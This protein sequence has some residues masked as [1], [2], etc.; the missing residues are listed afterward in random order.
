MGLRHFSELNVSRRR[1]C[2]NSESEL[3]RGQINKL[4]RII[5]KGFK[6]ATCQLA[7]SGFLHGASLNEIMHYAQIMNASK[8][9]YIISL[10][11][12]NFY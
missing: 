12:Y 5:F 11:T 6:M 4:I 9:I 1:C 10:S 7:I 8:Y 3:K 2:T